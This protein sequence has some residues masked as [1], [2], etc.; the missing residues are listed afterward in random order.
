MKIKKP[1][2]WDYTKPNI[3]AYILYPLSL[4]IEIINFFKT[5]QVSK[6]FKIK[7]ICVGNIYLGGTGK[8]SLCIKINNILRNKNIKTCFIKKFYENQSDEQKILK[9]KGNLFVSKNRI[10]ALIQAEREGYE[11]AIFDDGL[12]DKSIDY[13]LKIVCFNNVNWIGNGMTIPSGPLREN[14]NVLKKYKNVFLNGNL[15][16]LEKLKQSIY[17]INPD[18][19]LYFGKYVPINLHEFKKNEK[20]IVFSGIGNHNTFVSM[21]KNNGFEVIRE[22]EFPDHYNYSEKEI[23][24]ILSEAEKLNCEI[25]TTE[26]DMSRINEKY[27]NKIKILKS[28]LKIIDEDNFIKSVI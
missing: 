16:D 26:K 4:I 9:V 3:Y 20:Y 17:D 18:I 24:D 19:N 27:S 25:I 6:K 21:V 12:Q 22:I 23:N 5:M 14:I 15:E 8:T 10:D 2:F 1:K 7:S 28:E 13:D 11:V